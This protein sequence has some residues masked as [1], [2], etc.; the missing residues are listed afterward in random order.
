MK[1][2]MKVDTLNV[3][4]IVLYMKDASASD[5]KLYADAEY[6]TKVTADDIVKIISN[7]YAGA[8][9]LMV[10]TGVTYTLKSFD[11]ENKTLDFGNAEG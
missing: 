11:E 4:S 6:D 10:Q 1:N 5:T 3:G 7:I 2:W 9:V 8:T